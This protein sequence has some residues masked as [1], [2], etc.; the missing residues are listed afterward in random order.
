MPKRGTFLPSNVPYALAIARTLRRQLGDTNRATKT[1]MRW[2]GAAERTVKNWFSAASGPSGQHLIAL[3]Q[4]SDE[5]L[6]TLLTL[7][8]RRD[9]AAAKNLVAMRNALAE[10]VARIDQLMERDVGE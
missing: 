6:D 5:V 7:S 10:T 4:H 9:L 2:T 1:V 3:I 8:G